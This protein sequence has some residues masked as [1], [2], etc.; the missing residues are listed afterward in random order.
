VY[1]DTSLKAQQRPQHVHL[2]VP[3]ATQICPLHC[4]QLSSTF[5]PA[6][7]MSVTT[8][9]THTTSKLGCVCKISFPRISHKIASV[10]QIVCA[11]DRPDWS[12]PPSQQW[13][14]VTVVGQTVFWFYFANGT[15][16]L[17]R[18]VR[19]TRWPQNKRRYSD[20]NQNTIVFVQTKS[21]NSDQ[22]DIV[23]W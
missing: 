2:S 20:R 18:K 15:L 14:A 22:I 19:V 13:M 1:G 17:S 23:K 6:D 10:W 7:R 3:V 12:V 9:H 4:Q 16:L 5:V 8:G 11:T 21:R